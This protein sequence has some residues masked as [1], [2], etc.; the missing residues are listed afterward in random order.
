MICERV[1]FADL[2][3]VQLESWDDLARQCSPSAQIFSGP[4]FCKHIN[5]SQ[6]GVEVLFV[7]ENDQLVAVVPVQR[8]GVVGGALGA[9]R[10]VGQEISDYFSPVTPMARAFDLPELLAK[11][12]VHSLFVNHVDLACR[13]LDMVVNESTSTYRLVRELGSDADLWETAR[14][15]NRKYWL[16]ADRCVRRFTREIGN[17]SFEL[18]AAQD[19]GAF[20]QFLELKLLQYDRTGQRSAPLFQPRI[21]QALRSMLADGGGQVRAL[22]SVLKVDNKLVAAHF[23][24]KTATSLHYWFPAY[25]EQHGVYSPGKVLMAHMLPALSSLGVETIDFGEGSAPYK[26]AISNSQEVLGKA[27]LING[28]LGSIAMLPKRIAWRMAS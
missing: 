16:D 24:M 14:K 19:L 26:T 10:Q 23:G 20:N 2:T 1:K 18:D 8:D 3:S 7:V 12:G 22:F 6:P 4:F 11:T 25:D 28:W 15:V 17:L 9:Y 21:Q 13:R 27:V 5:G